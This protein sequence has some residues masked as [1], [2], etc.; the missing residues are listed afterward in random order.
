VDF[1]APVQFTVDATN[2]Y[3]NTSYP[4][5]QLNIYGGVPGR[6]AVLVDSTNF[7]T[8]NWTTYAS[9][10]LIADIGSTEGWHNV[11]V[12]LLNWPAGALQTWQYKRLKLDVTPPQIIVTNPVSGVVTVP[13]IQFQGYSPEKLLA[14]SCDVSN[15][16][17]LATNL[18]AGITDQYYDMNTG[19]FTTNYFECLDIPLTNGPN[20]IT[21]H[22]TD[23]A[24][25]V[26]TT[27]F[28]FTLD[29]S[30]ATNP[31]IQLFWPRNGEQI[32]GS[33]FTWRG[34]VDD[35]TATISASI[36]DTN[37]N[38]TVVQGYTER[39]GNFWVENLPMPNGTNSL[40]LAVTNSAG[41]GS[42][43]NIF[44]S[45]NPLIVTMTPVPDSQL[46]NPTVTATGSISD[47]TYS[48]WINGVK[49]GV[50]NG[51][52]T[53]NNVPMT[54]GGVAIFNITTYAPGET[55]PDNSHGN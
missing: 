13:M 45:T 50:T 27:N 12:G 40:T 48:L 49:A 41:Y 25:N 10:S 9:P 24:G 19:E 21:V 28:N 18:P 44:V 42:T 8:A 31:V 39:N 33:N 36:T 32:S 52:W 6:Y 34:W 1:T 23:L 35:P 30:S 43:T 55:Q 14:I 47:S 17:G 38:T 5:L 22:A 20:T 16:T 2:N 15:A 37:G 26:T 4:N 54:P 11:W 29:Y 53:A 7:S 46:W 3:V 51:T